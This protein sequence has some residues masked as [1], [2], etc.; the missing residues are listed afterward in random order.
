MNMISFFI[1]LRQ[2]A[3]VKL[4]FQNSR[5]I[6]T[7]LLAQRFKSYSSLKVGTFFRT[8]CGKDEYFKILDF[9]IQVFVQHQVFHSRSFSPGV[10]I[11]FENLGTGR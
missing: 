10:V 7:G 6:K 3:S 9:E 11:V 2:E 5:N 1:P 8:P 4:I